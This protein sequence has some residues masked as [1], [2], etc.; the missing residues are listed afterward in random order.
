MFS[1]CGPSSLQQ[2]HF[3]WRVTQQTPIF[4]FRCH[5]HVWLSGMV[6]G[7]FPVVSAQ[8]KGQMIMPETIDGFI[9]SVSALCSLNRSGGLDFTLFHSQRI[10]MWICWWKTWAEP[11]L[12]VSYGKSWKSWEYMPRE[13]CSSD[14][15]ATTR[16]L[17]SSPD[18]ALCSVTGAGPWGVEGAFSDWTLRPTG[19]GGDVRWTKMPFA[20]QVLPT[21]WP[22]AAQ[23]WIHAPVCWLWWRLPFGGMFDPKAAG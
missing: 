15:A 5:Q 9:A 17:T 6:S 19:L 21:L 22:H 3:H 11:Y 2:H 14:L 10:A 13:S 20:M 8:I 16:T 1:I 12:R 18:L 4:H 7:G 23:L